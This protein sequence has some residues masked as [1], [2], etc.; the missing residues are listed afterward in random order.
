MP[1][2]KA[3]CGDYYGQV[4]D[5]YGTLWAFSVVAANS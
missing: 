2:D 4:K 1:F 5:K 3:P